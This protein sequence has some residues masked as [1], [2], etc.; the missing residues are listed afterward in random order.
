V[1]IQVRRGAYRMRELH[2]RLSGR[3]L[4]CEESWPYIPHLTILKT[5]TNEQASAAR[6]MAHER[7]AQFTGKREVYVEELVFVRE[8][9]GCWQDVAPVPL[10]HRELSSK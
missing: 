9:H 8:N 7:W 10:G 5:E 3:G 6:A 1:F 4:L 2:D